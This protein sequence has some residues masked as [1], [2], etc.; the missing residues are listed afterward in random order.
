MILKI[1]KIKKIL[2]K[3]NVVGPVC[4]SGDF[5]AKGIYLEK[6]KKNDIVCVYSAGPMDFVWLVI[7]IKDLNLLK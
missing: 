6:T 2:S 1:W 5:F 4:E 7:T 3:C